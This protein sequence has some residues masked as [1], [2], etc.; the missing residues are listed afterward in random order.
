MGA[1]LYRA[2]VGDGYGRVLLNTCMS[3]YLFIYL[4][5]PSLSFLP[6]ITQLP[7][8]ETTCETPLKD[9]ARTSGVYYI[10]NSSLDR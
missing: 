9:H 1:R 6:I 8:I 2:V 5:N 4:S 3:S 7:T 10:T